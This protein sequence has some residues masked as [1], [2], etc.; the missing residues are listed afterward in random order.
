MK[1]AIAIVAV[2]VL[3][4]A[5]WMLWLSPAAE[6]PEA[7]PAP[8]EMDTETVSENNETVDIP[9]DS[10][11]SAEA[12]G[13]VVEIT[14]RGANYSFSPNVIRVSQGDRVRVTLT[15]DEGF[16]DFVIDEFGA[17]TSRVNAGETTTV[18]FVADQAGSFTFYCSVGNHRAMGMEG[19]LVVE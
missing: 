10:D 2:L 9:E 17:A 19:T 15:S 3:G 1:Y 14:V 11:N 8:Q 16:H 6:T 4:L 5:A 12:T 18:E 7:T 13:E